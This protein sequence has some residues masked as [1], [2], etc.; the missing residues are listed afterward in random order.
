MANLKLSNNYIIL[1]R[2]VSSD[3][4][5]NMFSIF[6]IIDSINFN[7][8]KEEATKFKAAHDKD[9]KNIMGVPVKYVMCTSWSVAEMTEKDIPV[10]LEYSI[11]DPTGKSIS[12]LLQEAVFPK[13]NDIFRINIVT[14]GIPYTRDG[15]YTIFVKVLDSNSETLCEA[16]TRIRIIM[17]VQ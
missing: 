8:P 5:D 14:E 7:V 2:D 17:N 13:S 4:N 16:S 1:S 6:K 3:S 11:I 12:T 10:K 9:D 15:K